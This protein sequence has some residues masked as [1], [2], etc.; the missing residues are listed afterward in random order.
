MPGFV[1]SSHVKQRARET[2]EARK[3]DIKK[4]TEA[5]LTQ[6][7]PSTSSQNSSPLSSSSSGPSPFTR[8]K[9]TT[10][11]KQSTKAT[12]TYIYKQSSIV[13]KSLLHFV[14]EI[15][16]E[17]RITPSEEVSLGEKTQEAMHLRKMRDDLEASLGREPTDEEW[18]ASA[19]KLNLVALDGIM[20]EGLRAK[21]KL[22][23]A[24]LRLV[25][26]VVNVYIRNGL[27]SRYDAG[28][29]MQEGTIALI[30]AA[31]KFNPDK[32]FRF[33]TYA[34]FWIRASVKRSQLLQSRDIAV[35]LRLQ[36][37][38]KKYVATQRMLHS[39]GKGSSLEDCSR[40]L[41]IDVG[42]LQKSIK[43]MEQQVLSLDSELPDKNVNQL[44]RPTLHRF[45]ESKRDESL[46]FYCAERQLLRSDL[47]AK[48]LS[49]LSTQA[50]NLIILRY[51]LSEEINDDGMSIREI[52]MFTGLKQDKIR[53][54]VKQ[55][56]GKMRG[57]VGEWESFIG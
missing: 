57:N 55:G 42:V 44:N 2:A 30:R 1:A 53:R 39:S 13:P 8:L 35:P 6:S 16:M 48:L 46:D 7:P 52:S 56:L 40:E 51:G 19:G 17:S 23:T 24:N 15:H 9:P 38:H 29:L 37:I 4:Q 34:M 43:A 25:Q 22:V 50:A 12:Q 36:E 21:N 18:A 11:K 28:D 49:T 45:V 47:R 10:T 41:G 5:Q 33:S 27:T 32:G 20:A 31:E 3:N 14:N 26:R 54:I